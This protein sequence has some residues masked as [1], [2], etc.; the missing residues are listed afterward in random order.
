MT[1]PDASYSSD[2]ACKEFIHWVVVN[3]PANGTVSDGDQICSYMGAAPYYN[4]GLQ[5]YIF[6]LYSQEGNKLTRLQCQEAVQVFESRNV[7]LY[8]EWLQ[9]L[10]SIYQYLS[11]Q[12]L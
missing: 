11:H 6:L 5:R 9:H 3:I 7:S 4:S 12:E 2:A 8:G 10:P 1:D